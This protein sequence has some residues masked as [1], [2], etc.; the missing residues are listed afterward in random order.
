MTFSVIA[1][2]IWGNR[3]AE[4]MLETAVGR[5]R[6]RFPD[7]EFAVFS[8]YPKR[9]RSLVT[10]PA[11]RVHS[12]TPA[13]LVLVLFPL[14]LLAAPIARLAGS[15]PPPFPR[16]VRDLAASEALIDLAG[17]SFIDGR[18]KFLPFNIL[19]ILPAILLRTPVFKLAQA[20]GPFQKR[21]NRFAARILT[22]C[23]LVVA[24]GEVT[25]GHMKDVDFPA[26]KLLEAPD[27]A[28][29][30]ESRDSLS[31]EGAQEAAELAS[32]IDEL[33]AR[34]TN[35]V[36]LCPSAVIAGKAA[37]E[38]WDYVGF[39]TRIVEGLRSSGC[40]VVL[41]PNATRASRPEKLRNN[42]LPVIA[43]VA[44]RA[45]DAA[46]VATQTPVLAVRGDM[47]AANI[48]EVVGRCSCV[49]VSRFHAMVGALAERVP[50]AVLGWSHKY[51][52]V[53]RRF[54]M[55]QHVFDYADHDAE[56]FLGVIEGLLEER[57]AY[58]DAIGAGLGPVQAAS[59]RQFEELFGRLGH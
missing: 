50:V 17:V 12:C 20:L 30:F 55:E 25:L 7:A 18:E 6:D 58:A 43:S 40:A 10:D 16:S 54:D 36:G 9:D 1:G 42:D 37:E 4:A 8:Y 27:V 14:S 15:V 28:F 35:V 39:L 29:V 21:L 57:E 44:D 23:A 22:R 47:S 56:A 41:F 11:V 13:Y 26:D 51:V 59:R 46:P 5:V 52:E 53:M 49:A 3:G 33:R 34:G 38:G 31:D 32:S 2:T 24:R 45:D 19:T 48:R